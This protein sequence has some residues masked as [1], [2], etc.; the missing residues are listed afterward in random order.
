MG[1]GVVVYRI[2][3]QWNLFSSIHS[4]PECDSGGLNDQSAHLHIFAIDSEIR[5][6]IVCFL[7]N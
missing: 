6:T 2:N 4:K 5:N 7:Q 3:V 1:T